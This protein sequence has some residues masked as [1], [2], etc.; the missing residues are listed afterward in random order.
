MT[1]TMQLLVATSGSHIRH[2]HQEALI[3]VSCNGI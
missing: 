2:I 1:C 3:K